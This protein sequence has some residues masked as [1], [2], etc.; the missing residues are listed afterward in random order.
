MI[1]IVARFLMM[2][3]TA[4]IPSGIGWHHDTTVI[5]SFVED[6]DKT[7]SD[8]HSIPPHPDSII[9]AC[10]NDI[11]G[12]H[13]ILPNPCKYAEKDAYARLACH[14][15]SHTNGWRHEYR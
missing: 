12:K 5:V 9:M 13:V 3:M 7:C 15:M 1:D 6:P 4:P 11:G 14:E 8:M 10:V 2:F